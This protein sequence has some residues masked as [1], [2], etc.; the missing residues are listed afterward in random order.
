MMGSPPLGGRGARLDS[1][2]INSLSHDV[3]I[4]TA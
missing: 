2:N 3:A 1:P 4:V